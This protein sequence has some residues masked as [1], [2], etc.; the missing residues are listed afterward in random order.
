MLFESDLR[1]HATLTFGRPAPETPG[2]GSLYVIKDIGYNPAASVVEF[3]QQM[4][5]RGGMAWRRKSVA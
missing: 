3:R 1:D 2:A 5:A 4:P